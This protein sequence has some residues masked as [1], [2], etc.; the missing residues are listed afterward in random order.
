MPYLTDVSRTD[1]TGRTHA[2]SQRQIQTHVNQ[3]THALNSA[4]AQ[5]LSWYN[6]DENVNALTIPFRSPRRVQIQLDRLGPVR[7]SF[8]RPVETRLGHSQARYPVILQ[9]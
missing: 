5:S 3:R 9:D 2:G 7:I 6:L 4:V 8:E 1:L